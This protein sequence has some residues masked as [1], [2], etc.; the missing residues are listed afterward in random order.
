MAEFNENHIEMFLGVVRKYMQMRGALSQKDLAQKAEVGVSTMSRFL[1]QKTSELN[2]QLIAK[3]VA[4]LNIPMHEIIDFISEEFTDKF[5][6]LVKFYRDDIQIPSNQ[7]SK[8]D[9]KTINGETPSDTSQKLVKG[10]VSAGGKQKRTMVFMPDNEN[11]TVMK[12]LEEKINTLTPRQKAYMA[13]FL[14]LDVE[15]KDLLVDV[16]TSLLRYIRQK[17]MEF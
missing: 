3:I 9:D 16:G 13:D 7:N 5:T 17:G 4:T 11:K 8:E 2:P 6:R 14:N 1:N 15:G 12:T 10:K